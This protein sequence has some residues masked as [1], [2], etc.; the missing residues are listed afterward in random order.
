M[1]S[2]LGE[3]AEYSLPEKFNFKGKGQSE[4][5]ALFLTALELGGF[6][7]KML[8]KMSADN[9]ELRD[10]F[11]SSMGTGLKELMKVPNKR[12]R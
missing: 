8:N 10:K 4:T 6:D 3:D 7:A 1:I 11:L 2:V 9:V 5:I 12:L